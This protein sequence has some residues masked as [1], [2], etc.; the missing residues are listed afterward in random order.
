MAVRFI[1]MAD[2]QFGMFSAFSKFSE[3]QKAERLESGM[4]LRFIEDEIVDLSNEVRLFTKAVE[5]TNQLDPDFVVICGD[6]THDQNSIEQRSAMF[7]I[8]RQ[9]SGGID[10]HWVAGNHDVGKDPT[11]ESLEN[12]RK[13][14]G[15]D[16]YSFQVDGHSFIVFNSAI[17]FDPVNV[18]EEWGSL[19]EFL[20]SE[21]E[22]ADSANSNGAI[23]FAHHPL[24]L[25]SPDEAD[26]THTIPLLT[27]KDIL[28]IISK[29]N[30]KAI[31]SGH[32]H[33]NNYGRFN[34]VDLISS[35]SVGY[36]L[37]SDPSGI[38]LVELDQGNMSHRYIS[39]ED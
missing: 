31:Y 18:E 16:N 34:N 29:H 22:I 36:T 28:N 26:S 35:G 25:D 38:R 8:S 9:L 1:Q 39:L 14:Y 4:I 19:K 5:I 2:P 37:G 3:N 20:D 24:F 10:L 15:K 12:F 11:K 27:R 13:Y 23:L 30:V 21:L 32:L 33:R 6:K 17:C 7:S